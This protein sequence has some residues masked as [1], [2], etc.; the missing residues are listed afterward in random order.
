MRYDA[1]PE[2]MSRIRGDGIDRAFF[3]VE[4]EGK[5]T[6]FGQPEVA[7]ELC[8]QLVCLGAEFAGSAGISKCDE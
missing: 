1:A 6:I 2:T 8:F 4:R 5:K 7:V 3:T